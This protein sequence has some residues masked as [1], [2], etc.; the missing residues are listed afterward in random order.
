MGKLLIAVRSEIL[1]GSIARAMPKGWETHICHDGD[2]ALNIL[3]AQ[4]PDA[5][6]IELRLPEKDG[7]AVLTESFPFLPPAILALTDHT[8]D[9]IQG[10]A[11]S[12][13][14]SYFIQLPSS[15]A[16][17][18]ERITDIAASLVTPPSVLSRHLNKLGIKTGIDGYQCMLIVIPAL[19]ENPARRLHKEV[20]PLAMAACNLTDARCV[21]R[22]IRFAIKRAW[23]HRDKDLWAYYFP[24]EKFGDECPCNK[25]FL[26]RLAEL[27]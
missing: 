3:L 6:I 16:R 8:S 2:T 18:A 4:K 9:Y 27:I 11:P 13:G 12:L 1:A 5:L 26:R 19:K 15:S 24:P 25:V 23:K 7:L 14:I 22:S 20:Y 21:E 17:I 10:A